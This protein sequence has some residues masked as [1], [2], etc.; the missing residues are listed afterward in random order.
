MVIGNLSNI[1]ALL[2]CLFILQG[3]NILLLPDNE[4]AETWNGIYKCEDVYIPAE[5]GPN[6]TAVSI[7]YQLEIKK[8]S[9]KVLGSLH[10]IGFQT[11]DNI[12]V[13]LKEKGNKIEVVFEKFI[14]RSSIS[15]NF[16]KGDILFTLTR[17]Q[18]G[19]LSTDWS[20]IIKISES[21]EFEKQ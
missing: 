10:R 4:L 18:S 15:D 2:M 21:S 3:K 20:K 12:E 9:G 1:I 13:S 17:D 14:E 6:S 8:E 11:F 19:D 16:I 5:N 7:V